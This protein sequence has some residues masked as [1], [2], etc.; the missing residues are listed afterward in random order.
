MF[1]TV[2]FTHE[3]YKG[4]MSSKHIVMQHNFLFWS[5][6]C[7]PLDTA[8]LPLLCLCTLLVT[9]CFHGIE[10]HTFCITHTH[11]SKQ[12]IN[13]TNLCEITWSMFYV[14]LINMPA[15]TFYWLLFGFTCELS[16]CV[17]R[18]NQFFSDKETVFILFFPICQ[19]IWSQVDAFVLSQFIAFGLFRGFVSFKFSFSSIVTVF[20]WFIHQTELL[21]GR[22]LAE[23]GVC[24]FA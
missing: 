14:L 10:L 6:S 5:F 1:F 9:H 16:H 17:V 23:L 22:V 18:R 2:T 7:L 24:W 4:V 11:F 21:G 15:C 8:R 3:L 12:Y 13:Q 20:L 19:H